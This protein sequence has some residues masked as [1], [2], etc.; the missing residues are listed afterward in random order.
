MTNVE[1]NTRP[2]IQSFVKNK[3]KVMIPTNINKV[4][5]NKGPATVQCNNTQPPPR[6][7]SGLRV[8]IRDMAV[9][10]A[11]NQFFWNL[12]HRTTP[13][14]AQSVDITNGSYFCS[15]EQREY[16]TRGSPKL[17]PS[18]QSESFI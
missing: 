6:R 13:I 11:Q 8:S 4:L 15:R 17:Y 5:T 7:S 18:E 9:Y 2:D 12:I 16:Q 3:E 1:N 14:C 10:I